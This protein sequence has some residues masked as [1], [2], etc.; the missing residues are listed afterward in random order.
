MIISLKQIESIIMQIA[1]VLTILSFSPN[2]FVAGI[3]GL[4][5]YLFWGAVVFFKFLNKRICID[6]YA[7]IMAVIYVIWF[8]CT[9]LFY[10]LGLYPSGGMGVAG[11]LLYCGIFY[12]IGL[13]FENDEK[14]VKSI[15][16]AFFAGVVLLTFTLL[17]HLNEISESVYAFDAKNQMG[18]MLGAGVVFGFFILFRYTKNIVMKIAILIFSSISL[19]S[20][21]IVASRT[22]VTAIAVIAIV[23]FVSKKEKASNDYVFA[24]AIII[25]VAVTI[26][27]LGGIDYVMELFELSDTSSGIDINDMTSGRFTLYGQ[28]LREF[29]QS[30]V[31]GIG[32][33]YYVDN[34][35]I[36][37]LR[38]G[39]LLLA[40]LMLPIS[41]GKLFTVYKKANA[42]V[43]N[44]ESEVLAR[45]VISMIL[46]YFVVSLMEGYPPM[47]PNTSVFFLWILIGTVEQKGELVNA[48]E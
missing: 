6:L 20:L 14:N 27:Y 9:K 33:A 29:L 34:F 4:V 15:L 5:M 13:N 37:M 8:L 26:S 44:S 30:P 38:C 25:A 36:N 17:P 45:S 24:I 23:S 28:A 31:I 10:N 32:A 39:G 46:F 43:K 2:E 1:I 12:I 35:I 21:L 48:A 41:Y 19:M 18:Q 16:Y 42:I 47:G 11:Y 7:K 22:P 40:I 3:C